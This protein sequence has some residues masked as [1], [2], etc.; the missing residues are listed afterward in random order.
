MSLTQG[1]NQHYKYQFVGVCL[2]HEASAGL[3]FVMWEDCFGENERSLVLKW[4]CNQLQVHRDDFQPK[5]FYHSMILRVMLIRKSNKRVL[6]FLYLEITIGMFNIALKVP[7]LLQNCSELCHTCIF[8]FGCL[9]SK[10]SGVLM[11]CCV[12]CKRQITV[13]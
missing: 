4:K 13:F 7:Y 3:Q 12:S 6:V 8:S 11:S 1:V 10:C 5:Q 9:T 2:N